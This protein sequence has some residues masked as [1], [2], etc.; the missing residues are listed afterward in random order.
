M[1]IS[2]TFT[3]ILEAII[4]LFVLVLLGCV[5]RGRGLIDDRFTDV[6]SLVLIKLFFPA[7]IF[8]KIITHFSFNEFSNW[9]VLPLAAIL[10]STVGMALGLL[11]HRVFGGT[12][13]RNEFIA[14]CGFQNCGYLPMNI[15]FFSFAG[16]VQD[17][18]L[19]FLFLFTMG[20]NLLMWS[21]IP[22]FLSPDRKGRPAIKDLLN[23]PVVA[24]ILSLL[25]VRF[26]GTGSVPS[27]LLNPLQQL[28]QASFPIAMIT[29]GSYLVRYGS[30][31]PDKKLPVSAGVITKLVVFPALVL[32]VIAFLPFGPDYKFFLFLQAAMPSAVSLVVIGSY[33]RADNGY[34]SSAIFYTHLVSLLTIPLWLGI[35][36]MFVPGV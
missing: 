27:V 35:F 22:S 18:L 32:A 36:R 6:L 17:R 9:W 2:F 8:S 25:W 1:E 7:L 33:T 14:G 24:T 10:F 12:F 15:I 21:M 29:L 3:T 23:A 5:L 31:M 20:F 13:P 30:H 19:V 16:L 11:V 34:L 26:F 4:K 28:G